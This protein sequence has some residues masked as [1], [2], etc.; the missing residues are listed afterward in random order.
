MRRS[1]P[2]ATPRVNSRDDANNWTTTTRYPQPL[3]SSSGR[4]W[5]GVLAE[6]YRVRELDVYAPVPEHTVAM[7]FRGGIDLVQRRDGHTRR[8]RVRAGDIIVTAAGEPKLL[9]HEQEAEVL[10]VKLAPEFLDHVARDGGFANRGG[11][12][13]RDHPATR[14]PELAH[15][16]RHF[17]HELQHETNASRLFVDSLAIQLAVHLLRH[18]SNAPRGTRPA[19]GQL[20]AYKLRRAITYMNEHLDQELS[21][22]VIANDLS[23][24][25]FHFAHLF[26]QTTG[27]PPYQYLI[28]LRLERAKVLL[29]STD[30]SITDI[31]QRVG[32]WNN[33]HFAVA[34]H[35]A[36]GCTPRE[37]RRDA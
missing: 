10:K 30:L 11:G 19:A 4:N 34:F 29:R 28:E 8:T 15:L 18:Y 16:C 31:A 23:M 20:P 13:I 35:R 5:Q 17:C 12:L 22:E 3:V 32:Y 24:S 36:T 21:L 9:Q 7:H 2:A 37:F 27:L 33:S 14:D 1:F 25:A 6:L 26:K